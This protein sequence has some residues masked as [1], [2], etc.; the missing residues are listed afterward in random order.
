MRSLRDAVAKLLA[1]QRH[2]DTDD[3]LH[4]LVAARDPES[5]RAMDDEQLVDNLL[6]F[7]LAGHETTA[8]ALTWTL[9]LLSRSPEWQARLAA[10]VRDVAGD[11]PLEARH[12]EKLVL[13]EQVIKESMRLFPPVPLMSRQAVVDTRIEGLDIPAGMSILMPIYALH[14]HSKRWGHPD[15]FDPDRFAVGREEAIPRYNTC[16][17]ARVLASASACRSR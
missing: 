17:S 8:K 6:T 11:A 2:A 12:V 5:G 13:V 14:R 7:Y 3:L 4:R 16:R 15:E 10:E 9:Y 1:E